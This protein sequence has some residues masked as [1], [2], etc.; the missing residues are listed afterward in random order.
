MK[1]GLS[2]FMLWIG[3][4]FAHQVYAQETSDKLVAS[5]RLVVHHTDHN[6]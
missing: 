2:L 1:T 3:V 4:F 6:G 5:I